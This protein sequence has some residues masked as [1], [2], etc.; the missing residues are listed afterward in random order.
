MVNVHS[1]IYIYIYILISPAALG[2]E[3]KTGPKNIILLDVEGYVTIH[4][5]HKHPPSNIKQ[6]RCP[7]GV[8]SSR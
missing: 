8:K 2:E 5:Y 3:P 7:G 6:G 1:F 4:P